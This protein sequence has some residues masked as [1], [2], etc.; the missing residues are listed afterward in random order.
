[1]LLDSLSETLKNTTR[2]AMP[3]SGLS[4][5]IRSTH[6]MTPLADP[7]GSLRISSE[8]FS[9]SSTGRSRQHQAAHC[10]FKSVA[11]LVAKLCKSVRS[12]QAA[13]RLEVV[14]LS[15]SATS[16]SSIR[17]SQL[18]TNLK[19]SISV[20][21]VA[22]LHPFEHLFRSF[23]LRH[24]MLSLIVASLSSSASRHAFRS[25]RSSAISSNVVEGNDRGTDLLCGEAPGCEFSK[26]WTVWS[27]CEC[28]PYPE[29]CQ[30]NHGM[31]LLVHLPLD[32]GVYP[33][34]L[35]TYPQNIGFHPEVGIFSHS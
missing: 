7:C 2:K 21:S 18:S 32:H 3:E 31:L 9:A 30:Q 6:Q 20:I 13:S 34:S 5:P 29:H 28:S 1:M 11:L 14:S 16:I 35:Q 15:R 10:T 19:P 24:A 23:R 26:F 8:N 33:L 25:S 27:I 12:R 22:Y 4:G 17:Y